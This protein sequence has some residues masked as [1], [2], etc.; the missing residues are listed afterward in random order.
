V[1]V[2]LTLM[3]ILV[4]L[5]FLAAQRF[6]QRAKASATAT[7]MAFMRNGLMSFAASCEGFPPSV[8][9]GADPGLAYPP[10]NTPCW[11]GPYLARW[12]TT[13][14]FGNGSSYQYRAAPGTM[15]AL[16]AQALGSRDALLLGSEVAP[17]FGGQAQLNSSDGLWSVTVP[18][19]DYYRGRAGP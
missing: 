17:I 5:A 10:P 11:T 19:G 12:P 16:S 3:G 18:I 9:S 15:A 6:I 13:T 2:V 14:S 7:Q 8:E 4:T 1:A